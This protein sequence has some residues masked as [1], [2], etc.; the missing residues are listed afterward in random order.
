MD[1]KSRYETNQRR[2]IGQILKDAGG[3]ALS[4]SEIH[5]RLPETI[6]LSTVYR[7]LKLLSEEGFAHEEVSGK[8]GTV[9]RYG[10][11]DACGEHFH[12]RCLK[13]GRLIHL[14]C[15]LMDEL[16]SHIFQHHAF[17]I[18]PARTVLYGVCQSC[19]GQSH[20]AH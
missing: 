11:P 7:T 4:A 16:S 1:L 10:E 3:A 14:D 6:S 8:S 12:L 13:C 20:A 5:A 9:Y 17:S 15:G 2:L 19:S 18:D